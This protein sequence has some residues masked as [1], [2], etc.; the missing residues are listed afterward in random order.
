[1]DKI[2]SGDLICARPRASMI[3]PGSRLSRQLSSKTSL[4]IFPKWFYPPPVPT[5]SQGTATRHASKH[6]IITPRRAQNFTH[7]PVGEH[8]WCR[9]VKSGKA[10][11]KASTSKSLVAHPH[12]KTT[13]HTFFE[14]ARS[15]IRNSGSASRNS[16]TK[17]SSNTRGG[18]SGS[19]K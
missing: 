7:Q 8:F 15:Y 14:N 17:S 5:S 12:H 10:A 18:K 13:S 1:M 3:S 16:F 4:A 11:S 19:G 9:L 6:H 2:T